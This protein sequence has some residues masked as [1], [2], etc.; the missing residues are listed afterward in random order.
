MS[1]EKL[2]E[3]EE[4]EEKKILK[5][6]TYYYYH[7]DMF[8]SPATILFIE[9]KYS[10][11][12]VLIKRRINGDMYYIPFYDG[13]IKIWQD[14][15]GNVLFYYNYSKRELYGIFADK[16]DYYSDFHPC[17]GVELQIN[18][19]LKTFLE[20]YDYDEDLLNIIKSIICRKFNF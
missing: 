10:T 6:N 20:K 18:G 4:K 7:D 5:V 12:Q 14:Q 11:E 16:I 8:S 15:K 17:E 2:E 19:P 13:Y 9:F 1:E 3:K